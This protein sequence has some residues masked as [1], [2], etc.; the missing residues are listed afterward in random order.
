[1][2]TS[3]HEFAIP[4]T[5]DRSNDCEMGPKTFEVRGGEVFVAG[6]WIPLRDCL[7]C[8]GALPEDRVGKEQLCGLCVEGAVNKA[9]KSVVEIRPPKGKRHWVRG[10]DGRVRCGW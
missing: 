6:E 10:S 7:R 2:K 4:R 1:M 5:M 9:L 8:G 3:V